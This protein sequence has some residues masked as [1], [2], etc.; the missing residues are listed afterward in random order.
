MCS[1]PISGKSGVKRRCGT[2]ALGGISAS[3]EIRPSLTKLGDRLRF[4][5]DGRR[6]SIAWGDI[7][8]K[9]IPFVSVELSIS[10]LCRT[11]VLCLRLGDIN[12]VDSA[13]MLPATCL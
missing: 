3:S 2:G 10:T 4:V 6:C 1:M 13:I 7:S 12:T 11:R 8:F 9:V 5:I